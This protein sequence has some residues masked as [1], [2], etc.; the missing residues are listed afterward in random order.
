MEPT[1]LAGGLAFVLGYAVGALPVAWL[2][3]RQRHKLDMRYHGLGGTGSLD[4]FAVGGLR[5]AMLTVVLEVLKGAIVGLGARLFSP[6]GWF[7]AAA[8]AGCVAGD[9]FPIGFRRGGRGLVPLVSGLVVALP[10]AGLVTALVAIPV[11]V[12]TSM[13]GRIYEVTVAIAVPVGLIAGTRDWRTLAP[14]AVIVTVLLAR[15]ELRRRRREARLLGGAA[16]PVVIDHTS[17][18][19]RTEPTRAPA[20][21]NPRPWDS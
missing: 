11:A 4:A 7:I 13:R 12:F 10:V 20:S 1:L 15:A 16:S 8:I 19:A 21:Q 18:F 14:A 9:A 2:L 6:T 17:G 3:V 5:T